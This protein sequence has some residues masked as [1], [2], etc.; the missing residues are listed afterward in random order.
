MI[1]VSSEA[2]RISYHSATF[3]GHKH[4]D[5]EGSMVFVCHV[6]LQ[7][8]VLKVLSDFKVLS[9]SKKIT[10]LPNLAAMGTV[11]MEI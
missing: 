5:S 1:K 3:A 10:T 7:D 11:V 9:P 8:D 6:T 4:S 2:N